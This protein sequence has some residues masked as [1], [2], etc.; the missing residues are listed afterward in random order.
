VSLRTRER[1]NVRLRPLPPDREQRRTRG[2]RRCCPLEEP[3]CHGQAAGTR[4]A[5]HETRSQRLQH[6]SPCEEEHLL[7]QWSNLTCVQD[8]G[9]AMLKVVNQMLTLPYGRNQFWEKYH[10][11]VTQGKHKGSSVIKF[12]WLIWYVET[13]QTIL[14]R[15]E[16]NSF[17]AFYLPHKLLTRLTNGLSKVRKKKSLRITSP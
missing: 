16:S 14:K 2:S 6:L 10:A 12:V 4:T 13:T 7:L 15:Q 11:G 8:R 9:H 1:P 17:V 3:D 5:P